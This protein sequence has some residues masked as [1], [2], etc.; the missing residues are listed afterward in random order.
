MSVYKVPQDVEAEDKLLGPFSFRQFIFLIIAIV[1]LGLAY[2]LGRLLLP[3][4]ILPIPIVILFGALAL[5]LRKDQ[6]MEVYLAAVISFLLKPKR[7]LWKPDGIEFLVEVVAP[8]VEEKTY[9]NEYDEEEVHRRLSYL[10]NLVDSHGWSIRGVNNPNSSMQ[11]DLY[12]EARATADPL[13][14]TGETA[15]NIAQLLDKAN[16][17]HQQKII[18]TMT[19][20]QHQPANQQSHADTPVFTS[21]TSPITMNP[22]PTMHQSTLTPISERSPTSTARQESASS[23]SGVSPAIMD[24][25]KNHSDLSVQTIQREANRI[26]EQELKDGK[27]VVIS[28]R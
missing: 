16:E 5:P 12:H 25:A 26:M 23:P 28:L 11:V 7:R 24:L 17:Q 22:Y 8:N 9:G 13:D 3:L 18:Q 10:A 1:N 2:V 27:E 6:P 20:A 4:G 21:T 15:Q 14:E 19:Q